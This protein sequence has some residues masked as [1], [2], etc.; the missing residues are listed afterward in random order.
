MIASERRR[1]FTYPERVGER[2]AEAG[3][4]LLR[5][6]H[7]EEGGPC[8]LP[9]HLEQHRAA[10]AAVAASSGCRGGGIG[11][12]LEPMVQTRCLGE[13]QRRS[14]IPAVGRG[15][16]RWRVRVVLRVHAGERKERWGAKEKL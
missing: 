3:R 11:L 1:C 15:V 2:R 9:S 16:I 12:G 4:E 13:V 14:C 8:A 6:G 7:L 10:A 5:R